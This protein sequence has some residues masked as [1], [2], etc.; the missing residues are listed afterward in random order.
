MWSALP[1]TH[2]CAVTLCYSP[3]DNTPTEV[4]T[5]GGVSLRSVSQGGIRK[6]I[7]IFLIFQIS[8]NTLPVVTATV[9]AVGVSSHGL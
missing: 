6:Q 8:S 4:V 9:M 1:K 2:K 5:T 7:R 3:C